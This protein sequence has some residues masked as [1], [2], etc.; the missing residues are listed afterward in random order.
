MFEPTTGAS[1]TVGHHPPMQDDDLETVEGDERDTSG[2]VFDDDDPDAPNL[3]PETGPSPRVLPG[4]IELRQLIGEGG[5]GPGVPR[6]PHAVRV[7]PGGEGARPGAAAAT[8]Q[9]GASAARGLV[10]AN[11]QHE[12]IVQVHPLRQDR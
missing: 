7:R 1:G 10:L 4:G 12:N 6:V 2:D 9:P 11:I 3:V 5:H 8:G